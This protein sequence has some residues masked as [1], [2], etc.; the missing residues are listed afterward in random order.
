VGIDCISKR[1]YTLNKPEREDS[2]AKRTGTVWEEAY[3]Q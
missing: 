3:S 2:T 1:I